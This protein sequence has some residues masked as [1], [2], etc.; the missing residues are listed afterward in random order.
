MAHRTRQILALIILLASLVPFGV[1]QQ[2]RAQEATP[3]AGTPSATAAVAT[4]VTLVASGIPNPRGFNWSADGTLLTVATFGA[5]TNGLSPLH[6]DIFFVSY[7][8]RLNRARLLNDRLF[9]PKIGE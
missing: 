8:Q 7:N 9:L 1:T 3:L 5:F 2:M 4:G 6:D